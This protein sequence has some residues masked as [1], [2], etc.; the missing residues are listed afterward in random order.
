MRISMSEGPGENVLQDDPPLPPARKRRSMSVAGEE[1]IETAKPLAFQLTSTMDS[2]QSES[3]QRSRRNSELEI[4]TPTKTASTSDES[5]IKSVLLDFISKVKS[6]KK[7]QSSM[8]PQNKKYNAHM[9]DTING[10]KGI[11]LKCKGGQQGFIPFVKSE[12]LKQHF[13]WFDCSDSDSP[14][15][16]RMNKASVHQELSEI[17][18]DSSSHQHYQ[19]FE[20]RNTK[21]RE[22]KRWDYNSEKVPSNFLPFQ[23]ELP[24]RAKAESPTM[25]PVVLRR[26]RKASINSI[27]KSMINNFDQQKPDSKDAS[28]E[29][30]K[31]ALKQFKDFLGDDSDEDGE[32]KTERYIRRQG[33]GSN[34]QDG[35]SSAYV[36]Y[37]ERHSLK[38]DFQSGPL[39]L[40]EGLK[41]VQSVNVSRP[42]TRNSLPGR[43]TKI[44][45]KFQVLEQNFNHNG[46]LS[47][48]IIFNESTTLK[49]KLSMVTDSSKAQEV[50]HHNLDELDAEFDNLE[51]GMSPSKPKLSL[52]QLLDTAGKYKIVS[53]KPLLFAK[54]PVKNQLFE[55]VLHF[56]Q[57]NFWYEN[58]LRFLEL[59]ET[60]YNDRILFYNN[61][62]KM[63]DAPS[64]QGKLVKLSRHNEAFHIEGWLL[65]HPI[66]LIV[67]LFQSSIDFDD[68]T[69]QNLKERDISKILAQSPPPSPGKSTKS[70]TNWLKFTTATLDSS[71]LDVVK[72]LKK[73]VT[74]FTPN[75]SPKPTTA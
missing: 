61:I 30:E 67:P 3:K 38:F 69:M 11:N 59:V 29:E 57:Q 31:L 53:A 2:L 6:S 58:L 44:S 12:L 66:S 56:V 45:D 47:L 7:S 55:S 22:P 25:S 71:S 64:S 9:H 36:P 32:A 10:I 37:R 15:F 48:V 60:I 28:A 50:H 62:C 33:S 74:T 51:Q 16:M 63:I 40:F 41:R 34:A 23:L 18:M 20:A 1:E 54:D 4:D 52:S 65:E 14:F 5:I 43:P 35:P 75:F 39:P 68:K 27:N 70:A 26:L 73:F 13:Q 17:F 72:T 19:N 21:Q 49:L 8:K 24:D 42:A 46:N